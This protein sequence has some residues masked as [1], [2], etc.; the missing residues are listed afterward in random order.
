MYTLNKWCRVIPA[1]R[2]QQGRTTAVS[3]R[4][5]RQLRRHRRSV[6]W[7]L[8]SRCLWA[9]EGAPYPVSPREGSMTSAISSRIAPAVLIGRLKTSTPMGLSRFK[10]LVTDVMEPGLPL[11]GGDLRRL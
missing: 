6:Q 3:S 11:R 10:A 4:E 8:M 2:C 7:R 9:A 1:I 5:H